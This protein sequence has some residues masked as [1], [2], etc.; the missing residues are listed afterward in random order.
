MGCQQKIT[1]ED[2]S[3]KGVEAMSLFS[4]RKLLR[5][6][7]V[8]VVFACIVAFS[9]CIDDGPKELSKNYT[10]S[11]GTEF[12]LIPAGEFQM[13]AP[14]YSGKL[15][16]F[17]SPI[18]SVTIKK[19]F[20]MSKYEVTQ[21]EW[22]E[23]MGYN[24]SYFKGDD[25]PVDSVLPIEVKSFILKLNLKE[26]SNKYRLP[27]EAEWEYACRAGTATR[28]SFG[29]EN[30]DLIEYG[31]SAYDANETS[32]PVGLKLPNPW[33]LSD[34]HGNVW[35][36]TQ[37]SWHSNY[38]SAPSDGSAWSEENST[39]FVGRGGSWLDGPNLCTSSF[40]GSNSADAK[41]SCLGFRLVKDA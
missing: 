25:L 3:R 41:V 22:T 36:L 32:H 23:I 17:D 15:F 13:G 1:A 40:R 34:M 33:G 16:D 11:L 24:P 2:S 10:N 7:P 4:K 14:S 9:G 6:I 37:D 29:D 18:H 28:F 27:T 31:W 39:S 19:P 8:F 12:V 38:E 30:E 21:K 20:Y 26:G 35:E 5:L